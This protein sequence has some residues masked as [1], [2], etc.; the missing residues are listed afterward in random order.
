MPALRLDRTGTGV[1]MTPTF[2]TWRKQITDP[3]ATRS[4][5][6]PPAPLPPWVEADGV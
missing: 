3:F 6:A 2:F 5:P 1:V 4:A